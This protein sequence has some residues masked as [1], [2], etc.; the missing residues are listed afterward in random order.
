MNISEK[1][2]KVVLEKL[3]K[4]ISQRRIIQSMVLKN[5]KGKYTSLF[6]RLFWV[7]ISP[8]LITLAIT[9][10]FT[11][12][13]KVEISYFPILILSALLPWNFFIN[14]VTESTVSLAGNVEVLKQSGTSKEIVLISV[15]LTNLADLILAFAVFIPIFFVFNA[16]AI[17]HILVFPIIIFLHLIFT[18]GICLAFSV[19]RV[20]FRDLVQVLNTLLMFL[21]WVTPVFYSLEMVSW[22]Y[23]LL[24][25][26]NPCSCYA[27]IYRALLYH[28]NIGNPFMWGLAFFYALASIT[29]GYFLFS[30][31][32]SEVL[33]YQ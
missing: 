25:I 12:V 2:L 4:L 6:L 9:F 28:G 18:L 17:K 10:V 1:L 24:I 14:S 13:M 30:R 22:D 33:E 21:F 15:V 23:R 16:S 3:L 26:L 20:Y 32:E 7:V 5:L 31:K 29:A 8:L 27:V 11:R 19:I